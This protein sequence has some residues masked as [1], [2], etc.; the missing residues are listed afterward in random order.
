METLEKFLLGDRQIN[1]EFGGAGHEDEWVLTRHKG[2]FGEAEEL[3]KGWEK[4]IT[5]KLGKGWS[6][7]NRGGY[8]IE[9]RPPKSEISEEQGKMLRVTIEDV[10]GAILKQDE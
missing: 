9:I 5:N 6:V 8:R 7:M 10:T 3:P 2:A 4:E 1:F